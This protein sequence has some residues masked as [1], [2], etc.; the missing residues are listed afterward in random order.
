MD[1]SVYFFYHYDMSVIVIG[2]MTWEINLI[3]PSM[4]FLAHFIIPEEIT[5]KTLI[6]ADTPAFAILYHLFLSMSLG[7][8]CN[9]LF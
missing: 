2:F 1:I 4:Y 3:T 6:L 8:N 7:T 9:I 5:K